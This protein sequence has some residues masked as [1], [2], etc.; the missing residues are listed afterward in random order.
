[1]SKMIRIRRDDSAG[2]VAAEIRKAGIPY[3]E[4]EPFKVSV[5]YK[6]GKR[7]KCGTVTCVISRHSCEC[8][9]AFVRVHM[10]RLEST[11][12]TSKQIVFDQEGLDYS[13]R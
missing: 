6:R 13:V 9:G 2:D 3:K 4:R 11:G 12:K 10:Q 1:M 5:A 7:R 8:C